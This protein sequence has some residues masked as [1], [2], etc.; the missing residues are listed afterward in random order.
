MENLEGGFVPRE[1]ELS[2]ELDGRH[3]GRLA[4]DEIGRPKPRAEGRVGPL[5]NRS[6]GQARLFPTFSAREDA[7]AGGEAKGLALGI[8][9]RADEAFAPPGAFK[10][11]RA[12]LVVRKELLEAWQGLGEWQIVALENVRQRAGRHGGGGALPPPP[13]EPSLPSSIF[14]LVSSAFAVSITQSLWVFF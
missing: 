14:F 3:T 8:A 9:M 13:P 6:N 2:L 5:H 12:S 11:V 7:R 10:V 4:G 1:T